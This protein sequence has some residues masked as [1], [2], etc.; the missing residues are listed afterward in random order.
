MLIGVDGNEANVERRVGSGQFAFELI[1]EFSQNKKH[2]FLIYLKEKPKTDFPRESENFKYLIFGPKKFWTQFAL[3]AK[4]FFGKKPDVFFSPSHY[5]PRF[6]SAPNVITIFDL[7]YVHFPEMFRKEDLYQLTNWTQRS[8]KKA[9]AIITISKFS[10]EDIVKYYKVD[11]KNVV[12][13]YPGYDQK[14]FKPQNQKAIESVKRK[15][16]IKNDYILFLG[17][18]QPRKNLSRLLDAIDQL[19]SRPSNHPTNQPTNLQLVISGKR[20]WLYDEFFEKVEKMKDKVVVIDFAEEKDLPALFSGARAFVL[21]SLYEGF[22]IPVI[23]A[24]ACGCPVIV[25][26]VSSLPEIVGDSAILVDPESVDSIRSGIKKVLTDHKTR[27]VLIEK[28]FKNVKRFSWQ[29]C[30]QEVLETISKV[31]SK[32]NP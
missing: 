23:E 4:L 30:A 2:K 32:K 26:D 16:K 11:P 9:K 8:A 1:R 20:G 3:P 14:L 10:K 7:S 28:G 24:Q 27:T 13:A 6:S 5:G 29:K 18:I 15:Y 31:A 22:G 17:T 21:P 19:T 25:S 12:V